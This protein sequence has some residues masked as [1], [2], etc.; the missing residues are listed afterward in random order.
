M[1]DDANWTISYK[2]DNTYVASSQDSSDIEEKSSGSAGSSEDYPG[3]KIP[4]IIQ[5]FRGNLTTP[6]CKSLQESSTTS[7]KTAC[8]ILAKTSCEILAKIVQ[9]RFECFRLYLKS[10]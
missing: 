1:Q 6:S 10:R 2:T 7:S 4:L 8:K 9:D 3:S 5:D